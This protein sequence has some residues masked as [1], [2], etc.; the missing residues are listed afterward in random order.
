MGLFLNNTMQSRSSGSRESRQKMKYCKNCHAETGTGKFCPRCGGP[1]ID[2]QPPANPAGVPQPQGQ[3]N[4]G[5]MPQGPVSGG[6]VPQEPVIH[7]KK[8]AI[9]AVIIAAVILIASGVIIAVILT[10]QSDSRP[11][12]RTQASESTQA[13]ALTEAVTEK[14]T[15][16][17]TEK[18]T[19]AVTEKPSEKPSEAPT[20][21]PTEA[22]TSA[23]HEEYEAAPAAEYFSD[24]SATS[25]LGDQ[26]DASGV[27]H[28]Y[29]PRNVLSD[30][31][32]CW[33][34]SGSG[35]GESITLSLSGE[36]QVSGLTVVNGYAGTEK[37]YR[38]NSKPVQIKCAFSDGTTE[39]CELSVYS[40]E[41]RYNKQTI[42]F[43]TPHDTDY[44]RITI[45]S[46]KDGS[47]YQDTCITYIKPF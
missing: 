47:E 12:S 21:K 28:S 31:D 15:A 4:G 27:I 18:V 45:L 36:Q 34:T 22:A 24:A 11:L 8:P 44:V 37:Q 33:S 25:T 2:A 3:V 9:I 46:V 20:V 43:S 10:S 42:T 17:V 35:V 13:A 41:N 32:S 16:A 29:H 26:K 39:T 19:E 40:S 6:Y 1:L 7:N 30:D 5:R 38:E 14:A 23:A